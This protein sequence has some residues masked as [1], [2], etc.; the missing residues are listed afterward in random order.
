MRHASWLLAPVLALL[1][2]AH[3]LAAPGLTP[4]TPERMW[5]RT[6]H[7]SWSNDA[8]NDVAT[9]ASGNVIVAGSEYR[10][11][12]GQGFNWVVRKYGPDGTLLW[13]GTRDGGVGRTEVATAV[14]T[15]AAGNVFVGGYDDL[16]GAA[17][18]DW[19]LEKLDA[20]GHL[21]WVRTYAGPSGWD[22]IYALDVDRR[23]GSAVV[24]GCQMGGGAIVTWL[25][26]KYASDGTL[27][28]SRTN[29]GP[30]AGFH[31]PHDVAVGA[32]GR[33]IVVGNEDRSDLGHG[34]DG[35]VL[36]Y[37][38]DG[39]LLWSRSAVGAGSNDDDIQ[40]VAVDGTGRIYVAGFTD[41][42][43]TTNRCVSIVGAY[44]PAGNLLWMDKQSGSIQFAIGYLGRLSWQ[45]ETGVL[46]VA[47]DDFDYLR[48]LDG[49][50][51]ELWTA[52][53][54]DDRNIAMALDAL[55]YLAMAGTH[56]YYESSR[57]W[58][59][60]RFRARQPPPC[61]DQGAPDRVVISPNPVAGDAFWASPPLVDGADEL[62]IEVYNIRMQRVYRGRWVHL[63]RTEP[64]VQIRH[65]DRWAPGTYLL[66]ATARLP[67]GGSMEFKPARVQVSR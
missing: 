42:D 11:D 39:L 25:T 4:C 51:R 65:V 13:S 17:S 14:G 58:R 38:Q 19:R 2:A 21:L 67:G 6:Y 57:E 20:A 56:F 52:D 8:P 10:V 22:M 62:V 3:A 15:D 30:G 44:D 59:V 28:W 5:E 37:D 16:G 7:P 47:Q 49:D 48:A 66:K 27:V 55:G 54:P 60:T 50:G 40:G 61:L 26:R 23:D 41:A 53:M 34:W 24:T 18:N 45:P 64:G 33:V 12:L 32:D 36:V 1:S 43:V 63:G 46:F 35:M 9:D 29:S 31:L